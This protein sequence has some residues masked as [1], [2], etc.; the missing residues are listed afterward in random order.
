MAARS[1]Q[2]WVRYLC[3]DY[4]NAPMTGDL[5]H[6]T[7][8]WTRDNIR[9][10]AANC[11]GGL[12]KHEELGN[13]VYNILITAEEADC[14]SGG[15]D[16]ASSVDGVSIMPS[17]L[18][19]E[20]ATGDVFS[21]LGP[22]LGAGGDRVWS[23]LRAMFRKDRGVSGYNLPE[24]VNGDEGGYDAMVDSLE[25]LS[26]RVVAYAPSAGEEFTGS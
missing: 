14:V 8:Y 17:T 19:F 26:D 16:G 3:L 11:Q 9:E 4:G 10:M 7:L 24:G 12:G 21:S 13:G 5:D 6:H 25:V 23:W 15:L 2:L 20:V 1:S 18:M 22:F